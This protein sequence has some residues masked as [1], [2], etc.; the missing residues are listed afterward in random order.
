MDQENDSRTEESSILSE[1]A[2]DNLTAELLKGLPDD[3][4]YANMATYSNP[5]WSTSSSGN[6]RE[7]IKRMNELM[8][9]LPKPRK[10]VIV[11]LNSPRCEFSKRFGPK[12]GEPISDWP[13]TIY[14][15]PVELYEN[16]FHAALRVVELL[17]EGPANVYPLFDFKQACLDFNHGDLN[18]DRT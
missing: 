14:G 16:V 13:G 5:N 12:P 18:A 3:G 9:T 2:I 6:I 7:S 11:G 17:G 1:R 15:I 4:I 8:A 10:A